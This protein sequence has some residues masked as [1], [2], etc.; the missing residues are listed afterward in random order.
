M[1]FVFFILLT[2]SIVSYS[3]VTYSQTTVHSSMITEENNEI[4]FSSDGN[5]K[6][7]NDS[8]SL[9]NLTE[10]ERKEVLYLNN[11]IH[12]VE[13]KMQWVRNNPEMYKKTLEDGWWANME[14]YISES[15]AKK[16][17]IIKR[18]IEAK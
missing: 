14:K 4:T 12:A 16:E 5:L 8:L 7:H 9:S 13:V 15:K 3:N 10:D 1:K 18:S 17:L 6:S 2:I 11:Y